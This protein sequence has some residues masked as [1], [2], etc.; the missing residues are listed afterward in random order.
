MDLYIASGWIWDD[1]E[2]DTH[3]IKCGIFDSME[4]AVECINTTFN[5]YLKEQEEFIKK[6]EYFLEDS[7]IPYKLDVFMKG[8]EFHFKVEKE[9][10]ISRNN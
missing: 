8:Y 10:L 6:N 7:K 2:C 5:N 3:K 9:L 1:E 4:M